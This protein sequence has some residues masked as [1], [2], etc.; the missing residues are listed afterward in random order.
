M[1]GGT[2]ASVNVA[3]CSS[4]RTEN[5]AVSCTTEVGFTTLPVMR[6]PL[7]AAASDRSI[8]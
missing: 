4:M 2:R 8:T 3:R 6:R 7:P 1:P 5:C